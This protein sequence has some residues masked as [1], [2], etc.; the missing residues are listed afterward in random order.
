MKEFLDRYRTGFQIQDWQKTGLLSSLA[1]EQEP[2]VVELFE[3]AMPYI[4]KDSDNK[5]V[6]FI[7]PIIRRIYVELVTGRHSNDRNKLLLYLLID[8]DDV[9][10]H[11][12]FHYKEIMPSFYGFKF[13]DPE[14][15]FCMILTN[16]YIGK[17]N[18]II[19]EKYSNNNLH[20]SLLAMARDRKI[21]KIL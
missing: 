7:L 2:Q 10:E 5:K 19:Q 11:F 16:D 8:V 20:S 13:I 3:K 9:I 17:I 21:D 12:N 1:T 6:Q 4:L 15:E 18:R 14:A